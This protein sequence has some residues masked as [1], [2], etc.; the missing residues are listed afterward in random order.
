MAGEPV[1]R[2]YDPNMAPTKFVKGGHNGEFL[3]DSDK[4]QSY[5]RKKQSKKISV[6]CSSSPIVILS[7]KA[8]KSMHTAIQI[9]PSTVPACETKIVSDFKPEGAICPL[10]DPLKLMACDMDLT[11]SSHLLLYKLEGLR[12][13]FNPGVST[14]HLWMGLKSAWEAVEKL[15]QL[16]D[17]ME[18][19]DLMQWSSAVRAHQ[20]VWAGWK[21][22]QERQSSSQH[23][24][25][26]DN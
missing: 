17:W 2:Y 14:R 19:T 13:C 24:E 6:T 16:A 11:V 26:N 21:D 5:G 22:F 3:K 25:S 20:A 15:E 23:S 7:P 12:Q 1:I 4:H 8:S 18:T 9:K 10:L